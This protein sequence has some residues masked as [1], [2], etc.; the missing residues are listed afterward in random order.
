MKIGDSLELKIDDIGSGGEGIAHREEYTVFVPFA[1]PAETIRAKITYVKRNLAYGVMTHI[2]E[3]SPERVTPVCP[4]Y[5][6]CGGCDLMHLNYE[7]Q[8]QSKRQNLIHILRKNCGYTG[9]VMP[10]VASPDPFHYRNKIQLPF[11]RKD[12]K[13]VLGFYKPGSHIL[14]P[15]TKCLLHGE[16]ATKLIR[17]VTDF[18]DKYKISVYDEASQKGL[19]RHLV[20][21]FLDGT[22]MVTLV[23]NGRQLPQAEKLVSALRAEFNNSSLYL[24]INTKRTNVILGNQLVPVY[25]PKQTV[26]VQGIEV[27]INPM[28]FFQ[29]NDA[30]RDLI[31][32][33]TIAAIAPDTKSIV[34]DAYSGVGL[35]G[36]ILAKKGA[37]IYNIE[38]VPEAVRDANK[39]YRTNGLSAV[40]LCADAAKALPEL[41]PQFADSVDYL[42]VILDPPRKGC[43]P[44]VLRAL[45]SHPVSKLIYI[46][47]NPATLSRD[48]ALLQ[49]AYDI[50][51]IT[52][53]DMFPNTRHVECVVLMS[54]AKE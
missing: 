5:Y 6:R 33:A 30:V 25:A 37:Q 32:S 49:P 2:L 8:L 18:A 45:T 53:Y 31:Y 1:L 46:S 16:W 20:A 48:L 47:C 21:R 35:L 12:G 22:I 10:M 40:N 36:A 43:D 24:S 15:L 54:R 41:I 19:L 26:R 28:S 52:P 50:Q 44:A 3:E 7:A 9:E 42:S 14:V 29:V 13:T 11:G 38:I 27:E 39:L 51:S 4:I 17:I 23:I 34:I